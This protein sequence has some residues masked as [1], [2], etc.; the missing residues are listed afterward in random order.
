MPMLLSSSELRAWSLIENNIIEQNT[1]PFEDTDTR[2][3]FVQI[4]DYQLYNNY[5]CPF[6]LVIG[7]A[8][9]QRT[10]SGSTP[11]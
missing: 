1:L 3:S 5:G 8:T 2:F 10:L 7:Y 4:S 11:S 9:R 6:E